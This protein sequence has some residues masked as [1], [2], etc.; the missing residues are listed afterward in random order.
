MLKSASGL[1]ALSLTSQIIS[2]IALPIIALYFTPEDFNSLAAFSSAA[3]ILSVFSTFRLELAI[4]M[5]PTD[6]DASVLLWITG[7]ICVVF[8]AVLFTALWLILPIANLGANLNRA[9]LYLPIAVLFGGAQ[10]IFLHSAL[11][12]KQLIST[13]IARVLQTVFGVLIQIAIGYWALFEFGLI[14]GFLAN[15]VSGAFLLLL[16]I[17]LPATTQRRPNW[18]ELKRV[19]YDQSNY[20]RFSALDALL[21]TSS[22]Q[23]PLF[24]IATHTEISAGGFLFMAIKLFYTPSTIISGAFA[25]I[26]HSSIGDM[27]RD[28]RASELTEETLLHL[29]R[30]GGCFVV[31]A[32]IMGPPAVELLLG[33]EWRSTGTLFSWMAPWIMLQILASPIATIMLAT[34]NQ[35]QLMSLSFFGFLLRV[36]TVSICLAFAPEKA[37]HALAVSSCG[38]YAVSI[39]IFGRKAGVSRSGIL[40]N[41]G[42]SMIIWLLVGILCVIVAAML[43]VLFM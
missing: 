27:H 40:S 25:K 28:E 5:V 22:L 11:R 30:F 15:I 35:K 42:D 17:D 13:G 38:F 2:I 36:G 34:G 37:V 18:P 19:S 7:G 12:R 10:S 3:M 21:N 26:Y 9:F 31:A 1:A 20:M 41:F 39:I 16:L 8:S 24:L 4:P 23:L 43:N 14:L 6:R 33:A 32:V 29:L